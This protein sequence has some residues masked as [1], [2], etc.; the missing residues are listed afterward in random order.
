MSELCVK[1][2][3]HKNKLIFQQRNLQAVAHISSLDIAVQLL[4]KMQSSAVLTYVSCKTTSPC[5]LTR[6]TT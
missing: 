6:P 3:L 5:E 1:M 4:F 2:R